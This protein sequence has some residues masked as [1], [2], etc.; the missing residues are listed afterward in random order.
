MS[1]LSGCNLSS[2]SYAPWQLQTVEKDLHE[3]R[4]LPSAD[5]N[6]SSSVLFKSSV[7][8]VHI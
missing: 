7:K 8:R 6:S 3:V 5:D 1:K 2:A 4:R